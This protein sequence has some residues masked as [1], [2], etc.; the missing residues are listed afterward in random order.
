MR[1]DPRVSI[2]TLN[3]N[4]WRDTVDC[5]ASLYSQIYENFDVIVVDNGSTDESISRIVDFCV[6]NSIR[7]FIVTESEVGGFR[8]IKV[9]S[10][11]PP[12]KRL[13]LIS[14]ILFKLQEY[15]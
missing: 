8:K 3:W 2:I 11:T 13:I 12:N 9:Y 4:G 1:S 5:L 10:N 15:C 14:K 7:P 6:K